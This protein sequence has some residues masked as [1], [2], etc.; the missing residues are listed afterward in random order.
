ME[1]VETCR[2][3]RP[4]AKMHTKKHLLQHQGKAELTTVDQNITRQKNMPMRVKI[5]V[6]RKK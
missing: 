3:S 4:T 6:K 2:Q 1:A 5:F